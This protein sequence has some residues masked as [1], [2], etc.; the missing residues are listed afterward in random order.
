[1]YPNLTNLPAVFSLM[2]YQM[3]NDPLWGY[4]IIIKCPWSTELI[5]GYSSKNLQEMRPHSV[6][7]LQVMLESLAY[8]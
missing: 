4:Y 1:M 2:L 7:S 6:Q 5:H 3:V 8:D